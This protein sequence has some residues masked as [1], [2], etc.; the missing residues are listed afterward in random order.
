MKVI[1]KQNRRQE[2]SREKKRKKGETERGSPFR[3]WSPALQSCESS[4]EK[5]EAAEG[6]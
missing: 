1:F 6:S 3:S 5:A 4:I 2:R